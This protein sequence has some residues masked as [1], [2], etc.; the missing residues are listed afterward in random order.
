MNVYIS[1]SED[2][3]N[4]NSNIPSCDSPIQET[5]AHLSTSDNNLLESDDQQMHIQGKRKYFPTIQ[6]FY[7]RKR[8]PEKWKKKFPQTS[9]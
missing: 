8:A 1:S 4:E 3:T 7:K 9:R 6:P 2:E 5:Q